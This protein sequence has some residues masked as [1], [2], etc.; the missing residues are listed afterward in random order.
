MYRLALIIILVIAGILW[1][2]DSWSQSI[3]RNAYKYQ[4][5]I[6]RNA[7]AV[8][9]LTGPVATFAGQIHQESAWR[10]DAQSPYAG[11]LAQFTP[12]TAKWISQ[13]YNDELAANTPFEPQW[14]LRAL[15]RYDKHL[16]DRVAGLTECDKMAFVLSA[17]N[18]GL[19][20]VNRD[21]AKAEAAGQDPEVY[22]YSVELY[23]AGRGEAFF[24][25]NRGYP[26]RILLKL[27]DLYGWWGPAINCTGVT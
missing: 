10:E 5:D 1:A 27:Q 13:T 15:V 23:N 19:G 11:G 20:W 17:Y 4:R 6:I 16:W 22:W 26:R 18:G 3:P 2:A 21:K 14:A 25:E 9:G 7:R 8:W 12:D 24:R